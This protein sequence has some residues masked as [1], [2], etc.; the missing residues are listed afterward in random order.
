MQKDLMLWDYALNLVYSFF[1]GG[2]FFAMRLRFN[3]MVREQFRLAVHIKINNMFLIK[4]QFFSAS[5]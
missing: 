2:G 1:L 4:S 3:K 5:V